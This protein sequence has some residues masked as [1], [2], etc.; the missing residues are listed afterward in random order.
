MGTHSSLVL[1]AFRLLYPSAPPEGFSVLDIGAQDCSGS[2]EHHEEL[3]RYAHGGTWPKG[4]EAFLQEK[5][6]EWDERWKNPPPGAPL[7]SLQEV[8][9]ETPIRYQSVDLVP[10]AT[11]HHDLNYAEVAKKLRNSFD[12]VLNFGT[13]EHVFN[14]WN[15]FTYI[16]DATRVGGAM[17]HF[18]PMQGYLFHCF[19]KYDP[20]TFLMLA[21]ANRYEV[22]YGGFGEAEAGKSLGGAFTKWANQRSLEHISFE[23]RLVEIVMRK[24]ADAPFRPP[25]DMVADGWRTHFEFPENVRSLRP[26]IPPPPV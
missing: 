10:A 26:W 25:V 1:N 11:I 16:H 20:K 17:V 18:L 8:L 7:V 12:F 4:R 23:S 9:A 5:C 2:R 22:L 24:T 14:Q 21:E 15:C 19:F 3:L 6:A 13:T